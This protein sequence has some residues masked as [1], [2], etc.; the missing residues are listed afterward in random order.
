MGCFG[1]RGHPRGY[2]SIQDAA[3]SVSE[4]SR[5]GWV[6]RWGSIYVSLEQSPLQVWLCKAIGMHGQ[7]VLDPSK[8]GGLKM[9]AVS[10]LSAV[11]VP[12]TGAES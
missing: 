12:A 6:L 2:S 10:M 11:N 5:V 9:N 1:G 4:E 7:G 3:E 8:D